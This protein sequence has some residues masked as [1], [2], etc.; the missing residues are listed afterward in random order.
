VALFESRSSPVILNFEI[1]VDASVAATEAVIA[2]AV[3]SVAVV[4]A[5]VD[6]PVATKDPVV[7]MLNAALTALNTVVKKFVVVALV[8][9][10]LV[11]VAFVVVKLLIVVVASVDVPLIASVPDAERLPF[12]SAKNFVFPT[13]DDP[14]QY[15]VEL[16]AEPLLMVPDT[17]VQNVDVPLVARTCPN[18][19]V[20]PFESRSSPVSCSLAIVDDA[21]V[22]RLVTVKSVVVAVVAIKLVIVEVPMVALVAVKLVKNALSAESNVAKNEVDVAPPETVKSVTVVVASVDVPRTRRVPDAIALPFASTAKLRLDVHAD[23]FQYSVD[24]VAEPLATVPDTVVQN[25]DVPLVARTCPNVPVAPFESRS[26]PVS[27]N[28]SIVEDASVA[29]PDTVR[30]EIV[31]VARV[32]TPV[33]TNLVAVALVIVELVTFSVVAVSVLIVAEADVRL[34]M[35]PLV[36]VVVASV[37]VPVTIKL[38]V[39]ALVAIRLVTVPVPIVAL[40]AVKLSKNELAAESIEEKKL[41]EVPLVRLSKLIVVVASVEVPVTTNDP[42]V[43]EFTVL[44]LVNPGIEVAYSVPRTAKFVAVALANVELPVTVRLEIEVVANV[45]VPS[46]VNVPFVVSEDVAVI[47]PPVT[48]LSV[49]VTAEIILEKKLVDVPLV[50]VRLEIVVVARLVFPSAVKAPVAVALPKMSTVNLL[51]SVQPEPFQ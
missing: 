27:C 38:V 45:D 39:V 8:A 28:L 2:D 14:F 26:S 13:H 47:T 15:S 30:L 6:V 12:A 23:P 1:V 35:V 21:R 33:T 29:R 32:D 5:S 3:R 22:A 25:V 18:V 37:E 31:V 43:V 20:A 46:A 40:V 10:K 7:K 19:P 50:N 44:R 9:F 34:F 16:V 49:A 11:V 4:V 24:P 51:F 42:V 36:I 41:V 17:V 48:V